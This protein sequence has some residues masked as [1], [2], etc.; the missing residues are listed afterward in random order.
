MHKPIITAMLL[1]A[2]LL[3]C[4]AAD[5]EQAADKPKDSSKPKAS[6]KA[7][8]KDDKE[9]PKEDEKPA[10]MHCGATCGLA[11]ICVCEPSTK[12]Q[13][14]VEFD[15][16]CEPICVAGCSSKPWPFGRCEKRVSCTSCCEEPCRCPGW[17][18][19]C[20]KL[21]K[22][23]TDEEVPT[24]KRKVAYIC[25]C[26]S[27]ECTAG[28]CGVEPRRQRLPSWWTSLTLWWPRKPAH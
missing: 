12:K 20:K 15:V 6:E 25:D 7:K 28:C 16:K 9:K 1:A 5:K 13:P 2:V 3:A 21:K 26:C 27:G 22:E 4:G 8:G 18:R 14:K 19:N 23:T 24:I 10:C 11:P 17:V